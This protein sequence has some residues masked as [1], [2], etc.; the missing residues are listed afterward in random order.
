MLEPLAPRDKSQ[1]GNVGCLLILAG[2]LLLIGVGLLAVFIIHPEGKGDMWVMPLVGGAFA[3]VG[4]TLAWGGIRGARGLSVPA[5]ELF[6]ERDVPLVPGAQVSVRLR[7]PGP[8]GIKSIRVKASCDRVYQRRVKP[9][10]SSTVEDR[11]TLW[12]AVLIESRDERVARGA[13]LERDGTLALPADARP[14]G[15]AEPDGRVRWQIEVFTEAG[16]MRA[17]YRVFDIRV[18]RTRDDVSK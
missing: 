12:E 8:V 11:E 10:S 17:A 9:N 7:Q 4:A 16:F 5:A 14:T 2:F 13:A 1:V 3:L 15:P 18:R 6:M